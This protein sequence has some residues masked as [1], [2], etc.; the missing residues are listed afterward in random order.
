MI[1]S[2]AFLQQ[3]K[4]LFS[5]FSSKPGSPVGRLLH[6]RRPRLA[7][8]HHRHQLRQ[9][10]RHTEREPGQH[11]NDQHFCFWILLEDLALLFT[12]VTPHIYGSALWLSNVLKSCIQIQGT[13][14][15]ITKKMFNTQI[16]LQND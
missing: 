1:L 11:R 14:A 5:T 15:I 9:L 6:P 7:P 8:L 10:G 16:P 4:T 3:L 2:F 13:S 12:S